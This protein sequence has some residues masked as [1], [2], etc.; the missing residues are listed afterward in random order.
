MECLHCG[1]CCLRL[2][3]LIQKAPYWNIIKKGNFFFCKIYPKRPLE[4]KNHKYYTR[5][6]PIGLSK[7]KLKT[8]DDIRFRIDKGW[9]IIKDISK[10]EFLKDPKTI[11]YIKED[12]V[13]ALEVYHEDLSGFK[14]KEILRIIDRRFE[15]CLEKTWKDKEELNKVYHVHK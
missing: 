11:Q 5:F 8:I 4:C 14:P 2:S 9:S 15:I 7:L 13:E 3:P 1:D 6:C 12:V 10:L